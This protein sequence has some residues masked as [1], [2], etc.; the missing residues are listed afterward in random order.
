MAEEKK[1][2]KQ[3]TKEHCEA[4]SRAL[5]G[6]PKLMVPKSEETRRKM[7]EASKGRV[8]SPE[9][10][11]K[12]SERMKNM[13]DKVPSFRGHRHTP[14]TIET[15]RRKATGRLHSPET[16]EKLRKAW[17]I[18]RA[19]GKGEVSAETRRKISEA[20]R[21]RF[22]DKQRLAREGGRDER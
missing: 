21:K 22:A 1:P 12:L 17:E 20:A 9:T 2:K 5:K 14:E 18:R 10:R 3:L 11:R 4:I 7:S 8:L 6:N 13:P 16:I 15:L 19:N